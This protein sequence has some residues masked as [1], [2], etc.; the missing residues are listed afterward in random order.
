MELHESRISDIRVVDGRVWIHFSVAYIRKTKGRPMGETDSIWGQEAE[1]VVDDAVM[2]S[3]LPAL[4]NTI[5]EGFLEVGG[6]KHEMIPLPFK[7]RAGAI[8]CLTF[9]DGS[10]LEVAGMRPILEL[11]GQPIAL[12]DSL[13]DSA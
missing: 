9:A 8:L 12:G 5:A 10:E 4:P 13:G 2:S 11:Y 1:L 6:V 7:R 3:P